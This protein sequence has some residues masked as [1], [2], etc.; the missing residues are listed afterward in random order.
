[1]RKNNYILTA[2]LSI[3]WSF[4]LDA[5][6]DDGVP[7]DYTPTF[8][9]SEIDETSGANINISTALDGDVSGEFL[10]LD[11]SG[12]TYTFTN[13]GKSG[14]DGPSQSSINTSYAGTSLANSVTA[15]SGMQKWVVPNT[16]TYFFEVKGAMGG[17]QN[18]TYRGGYGAVVSGA[19]DLQ[20]G[21][22]LII[23]VGQKGGDDGDSPGGGGGT[24]VAIGTHYNNATPLFVAGGG[25]GRSQWGNTNYAAINGQA[26]INGGSCSG[27]AQPGYNGNGGSYHGYAYNSG[28]G[29]GF[30]TGTENS[31]STSGSHARGFRQ[32]Y[33]GSSVAGPYGGF[34]GGG[35]GSNSNNDRDKGGAGGY[36]GGAQAFDSGQGGGG[37]SY[38]AS[39]VSNQIILGGNSA[40]NSS[41]GIVIISTNAT[42]GNSVPI[43]LDQ[44]VYGNEDEQFTINLTGEDADGGI[45]TYSLESNPSHG[46]VIQEY[47]SVMDF[48]GNNDW[49]EVPDHPSLDIQNEI[50]VQAWVYY[51]SYNGRGEI[52]VKN[53]NWELG[54]HSDGRIEP[55]IYT[56]RW[57]QPKD[58]RIMELNTWTHVAM[59]YDGNHIKTYINGVGQI[60]QTL[61]G[62]MQMSNS[63]LLIGK[64]YSNSE[65]MDGYIDDLSVWNVALS[66]QEIQ[67][68]MDNGPNGNEEGLVAFWDFNEGSGNQIN[69]LTANQNNGTINGAN[70]T[71]EGASDIVIY[72]PSPNYFGHDNF[73]FSVSD[74]IDASY[75]PATINLNILPVNDSPTINSTPLLDIVE[76]HSYEYAISHHDIDGDQVTLT[77]PT[78]PDWLSINNTNVHS[79]NFNGGHTVAVPYNANQDISDQITI[80]AWIMIDQYQ[81]YGAVIT[82][83]TNGWSEVAPYSLMQGYGGY[84][85]LVYNWNGSNSGNFFTN[86][87]IP[88][89]TWTHV[90]CV[91]ESNG[92]ASFY[93]NG[94]LDATRN[95]GSNFEF[96]SND[97]NLVIGADPPGNTEYWYGKL[98]EIRLW[99]T[100][101]TSS[102]INS[103]MYQIID[104][105]SEGLIAYWDFN[106]GSGNQA[107]DL[108]E[109]ENNGTIIGAGWSN[110][111]AYSSTSLIGSPGS[112]D[113]GLHN[114]VLH[115]E[116]GNG[117]SATQSFNIAVAVT[118]LNITGESGFRILSSPVSG[119]IFGDLLEELWIQGS[120]GSDHEGADPNLWTYDDGWVPVADLYNDELQAGQGFVVYVFADTD[121]D[122][123][124]DLP[125]TLSID[126]TINETGVT[127]AANPTKWNL[128]GNPYGLHVNI[129]QMLSDNSSKFHS[130]VY[131][132]DDA[133]PGYRTHNGTIGDIDQG[134]I[135]PFDGFWV[136]ADTDGDV[137]EFTEQ[138]IR[139]GHINVGGGG[140]STT[141]ESA[142]TATFTFTNGQFTSNVYLSFTENGEI[143]LDPADAKQIIPMS[144]AEHLTSMIHESGK[145]LSINNLPSDLTTD[146]SFDLDVM[147]LTP[148]DEGY[149]TQSEQVTMTWDVS[150]LPE[151]ISLSL[152][153]NGTGQTVNLYGY[154]SM[155]VS[156]P[157]K[158]GFSFPENLMETYPSVGESQFTLSVYTDIASNDDEDII[159]PEDI[160]L[161]NA[162]PNPFNPNTVISFDIAEIGDVS[163][164][165]FDLTGRQVASLINEFMIPG[166]HQIT[167]NPGLLPSGVYLVELIVGD[168]SFNQKITYIK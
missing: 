150:D 24:A 85:R 95:L 94:N 167:W 64:W 165:I 27:W 8:H 153:N 17:S 90:A 111:I 162:Y 74:G 87:I 141:N 130:T 69:D 66:E 96:H 29:A 76:G 149:E 9:I 102:E 148:N 86:S 144:P 163:L 16:G 73:T 46:T 33:R 143:N 138:S 38:I 140:R 106:E 126:G 55:S 19:I 105:S 57:H 145:S 156:L 80:E 168:K 32:G 3:S 67:T 82:K 31:T 107:H 93:I 99:S 116:D 84:M 54:I 62:S 120:D 68:I 115:I 39:S 159:V 35:A 139:R 20:A 133:N 109:N 121:F 28:C 59:T 63:N 78:K 18:S 135:K 60:T 83:G 117:G 92:Y 50:T 147:L 89:D 70:W 113:G 134:L 23:A 34:G 161:H 152:V 15:L 97:E 129:N 11:G 91:V 101:R 43:A 136:Q 118:H 49:I 2:L 72:T 77:A 160:T 112:S 6:L 36:S 164:K 65:W 45:L 14:P 61:S 151:G 125:V 142:G 79:L 98:D 30:Y 154:P 7:S 100:A 127:V 13:C 53:Q 71:N 132:L 137:F 41:H 122:G 75:Q 81:D 131:R 155:N 48:D 103:G 104:P 108:T 37:G 5:Y 10:A 157:S 110:D 4:A 166:S 26:G 114:V 25:G 119:A 88:L 146:I 58:S 44:T 21:E 1:M 47:F 42:Q 22:T 40:N 51:R 128:V 56:N 124:D 158:G 12:T 52:C 123:D